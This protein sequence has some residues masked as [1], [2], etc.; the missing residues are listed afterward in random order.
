MRKTGKTL[1]S[2]PT[3]FISSAPSKILR[4]PSKLDI[5]DFNRFEKWSAAIRAIDLKKSDRKS[6]KFCGPLQYS[7]A[8]ASSSTS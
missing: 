7:K 4:M 3:I 1:A 6:I 8:G 2:A 5:T